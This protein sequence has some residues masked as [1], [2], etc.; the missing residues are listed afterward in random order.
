MSPMRGNDEE[1]LDALFRAYRDACPNPEASANFMPNLWAKIES[2]Q[3]FTFS[4]RR[5]ANALVT[6][7]VALSIA[8]SVYM[9]LPRSNQ[10]YPQSYIEALAEAN[11][12]D[13]PDVIGPVSLDL[14]GPAR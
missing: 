10:N 4:F 6:A 8:L 14:S 12:L 1:R 9:S 2:R 11:T 3:R 13:T 7:A 5:M